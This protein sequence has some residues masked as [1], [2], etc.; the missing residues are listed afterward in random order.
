MKYLAPPGPTRP[1]ASQQPAAQLDVVYFVCLITLSKCSVRIQVGGQLSLCCCCIDSRSRL[2]VTQLYKSVLR[3]NR[4]C[5]NKLMTWNPQIH[6]H[7]QNLFFILDFGWCLNNVPVRTRLITYDEH[8][9]KITVRQLQ[10][11]GRI[12]LAKLIPETILK[13]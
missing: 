11:L 13:T 3:L 5:A 1:G 7:V 4:P 8:P 10:I 9:K 6:F 2:V 12:F